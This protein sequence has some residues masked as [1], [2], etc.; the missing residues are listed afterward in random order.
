MDWLKNNWQ[1][2]VSAL[3]AIMAVASM[4][5]RLT[6]SHDDDRWYQ[7]IVDTLGRLGIYRDNGN[8]SYSHKLP[9]IHS[10]KPKKSRRIKWKPPVAAI[11]LAASVSAASCAHPMA[12]AKQSYAQ[13]RETYRTTVLEIAVDLRAAGKISDTDWQK[14]LE[15]HNQIL[16]TDAM[17]KASLIAAEQT[18]EPS[19]RR[20]FLREAADRLT[21]L[22]KLITEVAAWIESIRC[23]GD[24]KC[25]QRSMQSSLSGTRYHPQPARL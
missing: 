20:R 21:I 18:L 12:T 17:L 22:T 6:P 19:L 13:V 9:L 15:I 24:E 7:V 25:Y 5:V 16:R 10:A 2:A 11:L 23:H 3:P 14:F 8:G 4:V 1:V